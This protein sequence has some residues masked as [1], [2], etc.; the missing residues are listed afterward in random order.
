[1]TEEQVA[2]ARVA[3][4]LFVD[5]DGY[6]YVYVP[7][8]LVSTERAEWQRELAN[9]KEL[10]EERLHRCRQLQAE[11][12]AEMLGRQKLRRLF[13]ARDDETMGQWLERLEREV[14]PQRVHDDG[15]QWRPVSA[16]TAHAPPFGTVRVCADCGCLVAGGPTRCKRCA[17][18]VNQ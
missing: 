14:V 16:D 12:Q 13:G 8:E 9:W 5:D 4:R 18:E 10:A 1:L 2:I 17:D 7:G 6:G 11:W 15:W 3:D